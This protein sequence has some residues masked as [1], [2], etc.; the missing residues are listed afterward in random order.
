MRT[1]SDTDGLA[2]GALTVILGMLLGGL[3]VLV[4]QRYTTLEKQRVLKE[5][6]KFHEDK[7]P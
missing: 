4:I 5:A 7:R 6:Y 1:F 3:A 2:P